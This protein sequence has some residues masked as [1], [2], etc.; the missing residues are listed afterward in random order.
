MIRFTLYLYDLLGR[1][2]LLGICSF[3]V[4]TLLVIS[5]ISGLHYKE[6]IADFLPLNDRS[7]EALAIYQDISGAENIFT[8]FQSDD[9]DEAVAAIE[10]FMEYIPPSVHVT[11]QV[12]ITQMQEVQD[13]IYDNIP[14]FLTPEDY[15]R[16]DS[17]L[18]NPLYVEETLREDK[19][20]LMLPTGSMWVQS[21]QRD[22]LNLFATIR[23][24]L[25][26]QFSINYELYDGYIFS[27]DLSRAVVIIE[28]PFGSS[29][30]EQ[31]TEL[32]KQLDTYARQSMASHPH[33]EIHFTGAPIIAVGNASRIK[34]DS[35]LSVTVSIVLILSLLLLTIRNLRNLLLILLSVGWGWLFALGGLALFHDSV[36]II[37][38]GI[39]SVILGI[40][41][42][43]PLHYI[44][45]LR[46]TAD[47]RKALSEIVT[48]LVIGNVTTVGAF[49]ALVPLQSTA[50]SDL[51]LFAS[52]LLV[53]TIL[54]SVLYLPHLARTRRPAD[55]GAS[56]PEESSRISAL[57]DRI[58]NLSIETKPTFVWM[59]VILTVVLGFFSL[60]TQFDANMSHINYMT[61][62][63]RDD[64]AFFQEEMIGLSEQFTLYAVI[65]GN[66]EESVLKRN[67]ALL[68]QLKAMQ[69]ADV[70][71]D[72][73]SCHRFICSADE[74]S[75]RLARWQDFTHGHDDLPSLIEEAATHE[76]F[77]KGSF[78]AFSELFE[79]EYSPQPLAYFR[80]SLSPLLAPHLSIDEQEG[81]FS[82]V[83]ALHLKDEEGKSVVEK[84][85]LPFD[86]AY[87]FDI[88]SMNS[89]IAN[90]LSDNFNYIGWACG[91]IVFF[92]LWLSLGSLEL[93][94]LSFIPMA[95]S[96][97]WI[98][99]IM[100][101][102]GIQFNIVN[103]ILATFIFGQGDDY[104]IFMTEGACY[105][106][107]YRKKMLASYK[108]A[109]ILSALIMLI[110]IGSL[111]MAKH[112]A[113][114]SLAE[115]TI[116]GMFSVVLMSALFPPFLFKI[117]VAWRGHYRKRP[118]SLRPLFVLVYCAICFFIQWA[119]VYILGLLLFRVCSPNERRRLRFRRYVQWLYRFDLT[120]IP[121]VNYKV[122][123]FIKENFATPAVIVC[124]HQSMLDAAAFMA[125]SPKLVL[126]SNDKVRSNRIIRTIYNWMGHISLH[127][128]DPADTRVRIRDYVAKGYSFVIFPEGERNDQSSIMR[129]H[130]GAFL[131]AEQLQLDVVTVFLHGF[132]DV[133]PRNS[134]CLF[135]GTLTVT[136][137]NRIRRDDLSWGQG[138]VERTR[139]IHRYYVEQYAE[140]ARVLENSNYFTHF[141]KDRY[142]YKGVEVFNAVSKNL[143]RRRDLFDLANAPCREKQVVIKGDTYGEFAL[144]YALI[145]SDCRVIVVCND[146][147]RASLIRF[148]AEG[149][150]P[151]LE[152]VSSPDWEDM[153]ASKEVTCKMIEL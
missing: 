132:N 50:L 90:H 70:I 56:E 52:L 44:A 42:N 66:N 119:S 39:S 40:A 68:P 10:E 82:I 123:N 152:V 30:T 62:Q 93:A 41:V 101:I 140:M 61:D 136:I 143:R 36:S 57:F 85:L 67:D 99:G 110:G 69:E 145:H 49:L 22:P 63:Q 27:S 15:V 126:I 149:V 35:I 26:S 153:L 47:K 148:S 3:L 9:P 5:L 114:R 78:A 141:V 58:A 46:H 13:F 87:C 103:I 4:I 124:N 88:E 65:S 7:M 25:G 72:F 98:L 8:I 83:S 33:V 150:A 107:A 134:L 112:P 130:K 142:R 131:L 104:T 120:H 34:R 64:M 146:D 37:V 11:A 133:L 19:R 81:R 94:I 116:T 128:T 17:L 125:L 32:A 147:E 115:V 20:Q 77:A 105:E 118:L 45:H 79:Q 96:W 76:G 100:A 138:Y 117:L 12:D 80:T 135:P 71:D 38:I 16:I 43:Y 2:R 18:A 55:V 137:L 109:I 102:L 74:Q 84:K 75:R 113:L 122:T 14:Y 48:P 129:F 28:S 111:I 121:T 144:L 53:G 91:F 51:G 29:E 21:M 108:H 60:R 31:N 24:S 23:S 89:S 59:V 73:S 86:C 6:D 95:V 1:H 54:F 92:F 97:I 106:Y 151:N 127:G 139:N